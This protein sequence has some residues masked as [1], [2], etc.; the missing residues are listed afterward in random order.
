MCLCV[1]VC[2]CMCVSAPFHTEGSKE[3]SSLLETIISY[4]FLGNITSPHYKR[5]SSTTTYEALVRL[6][7]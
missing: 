3:Y 4:I 1:C 6:T 2:A 5:E 7:H